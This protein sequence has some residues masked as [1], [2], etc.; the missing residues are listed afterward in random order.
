MM[1]PPQAMTDP[2]A[3][4]PVVITVPIAW[5][6]MDA[7][8]HVNNT[9]YF[10]LFE[11]ARIEYLRA[12]RFTEGGSGGGTG[13]ILASTECRFRRPLEFPDTV[14]VG[15]RTVDVAADRFTME[16]VIVSEK[17]GEVAA[18]GTGTIVSYDYAARSKAPLPA[19]VRQRMDELARSPALVAAPD[20]EK[21]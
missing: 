1:Q 6:D 18:R 21:G 17:L 8:G 7:Y 14:R 16:Y 3:S 4:F 2:L 11:S 12:I 10:R 9:V 15:A 5:G 13:P 19:A 20:D